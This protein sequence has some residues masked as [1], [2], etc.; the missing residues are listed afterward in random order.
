MVCGWE[1]FRL[2]GERNKEGQRASC[3]PQFLYTHNDTHSLSHYTNTSSHTGLLP[4]LNFYYQRRAL[5]LP[6]LLL[7]FICGSFCRQMRQPCLPNPLPSLLQGNTIN[8]LTFTPEQVRLFSLAGENASLMTF[9]ALVFSIQPD[10]HNFRSSSV[11]HKYLPSNSQGC[12]QCLDRYFSSYLLLEHQVQQLLSNISSESTQPSAFYTFPKE[13]KKWIVKDGGRHGVCP[14]CEFSTLKVKNQK[15]L[16]LVFVLDLF[17]RAMQCWMECHHQSK[18]DK[19]N[20]NECRI[21]RVLVTA[22]GLNQDRLIKVTIVFF[23]HAR[24][25]VYEDTLTRTRK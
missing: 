7:I 11:Q 19:Q 3:L 4:D 13:K 6:V 15:Y 23:V 20:N 17:C 1:G 5:Q 25:F 22:E 2:N 18:L 12:L 14:K 16:Q 9:S 10:V 24:G 8:Q 21:F